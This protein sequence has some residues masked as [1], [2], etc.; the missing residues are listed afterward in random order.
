MSITP[1]LSGEAQEA[2][3]PLPCSLIGEGSAPTCTVTEEGNGLLGLEDGNDL[4]PPP[5]VA[6]A[7]D[8]F[9]KEMEESPAPSTET[10]P[11]LS[12]GGG[13]L[14]PSSCSALRAYC[15]GRA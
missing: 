11:S 4:L 12:T 7:Q 6:T 9:M 15:P 10:P 13:P 5:N 2:A 3:V 8:L 1:G 14:L